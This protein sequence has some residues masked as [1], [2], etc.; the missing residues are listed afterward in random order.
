MRMGKFQILIINDL[1][2]KSDDWKVDGLDSGATYL[3]NMCRDIL[4]KKST[5][6]PEGT[7]VG[8]FQKTGDLKGRIIGY[9]LLSSFLTWLTWEFI[10]RSIVYHSSEVYD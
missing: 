3:I 10:E 4:D 6:L 7:N 8:A 9:F 2:V 5:G 1:V